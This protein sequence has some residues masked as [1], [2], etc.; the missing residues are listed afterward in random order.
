MTGLGA[1]ASHFRRF[2]L[3]LVA[4]DFLFGTSECG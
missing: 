1:L 4:S 2:E 3:S